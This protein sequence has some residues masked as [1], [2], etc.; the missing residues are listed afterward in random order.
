MRKAQIFWLGATTVAIGSLLLTLQTRP[1]RRDTPERF[2]EPV[3]RALTNQMRRRTAIWHAVS[4]L[5]AGWTCRDSTKRQRGMWHRSR[6]SH[7]PL[8]ATF[9]LLNRRHEYGCPVRA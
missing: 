2:D 7:R 5:M 4:P 3:R 6:D 1:E 8:A 9:P